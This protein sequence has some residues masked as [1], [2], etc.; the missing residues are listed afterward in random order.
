[1]E[2]RLKIKPS[3]LW[4]RRRCNKAHRAYHKIMKLTMNAI[5]EFVN[6]MLDIV[7]CV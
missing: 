6:H 1:L 4:C 3:Y 2:T 5:D 7:V